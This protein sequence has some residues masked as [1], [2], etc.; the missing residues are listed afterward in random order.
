MEKLFSLSTNVSG[1]AEF[2]VVG[3]GENSTLKIS[4]KAL[5]PIAFFAS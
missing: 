1:N 4:V 5:N 3:D 2:I